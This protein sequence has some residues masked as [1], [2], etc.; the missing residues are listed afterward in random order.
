ME[1]ASNPSTVVEVSSEEQIGRF[2]DLLR[3]ELR[4]VLG[5]MSGIDFQKKFIEGEKTL[6]IKSRFQA[7]MQELIVE[8]TNTFVVVAKRVDYTRTPQAV[9]SATGRV[10]YLTDSVVATMPRLGEGVV[11]NV[12]V[13][14]FKLDRWASPEEVDREF[15]Q[16]G[17]IPDPYVQAAINEQDLAFADKYPNGTQWGRKGEEVSFVAFRR[18]DVERFVRCRRLGNEWY[19]GWWFAGRRKS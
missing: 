14:F 10:E 4:P 17:L 6:R 7:F 5:K 11:E 18:F 13:T 12:P 15:E 3:P 9:I 1:S 16:R 8:A 2:L 19:G